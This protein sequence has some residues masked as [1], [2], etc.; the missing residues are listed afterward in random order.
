MIAKSARLASVLVFMSVALVACPDKHKGHSSSKNVRKVKGD[1]YIF[2]RGT[3]MNG[4]QPLSEDVVTD[5]SRWN[6][7]LSGFEEDYQETTSFEEAKRKQTPENMKHER[8]S[9]TFQ[10][11]EEG[12]VIRLSGQVLGSKFDFKFKKNSDKTII[13]DEMFSDGEK[14]TFDDSEETKLLHTSV[15]H[16]KTAMSFLFYDR[17]PG[18]RMTVAFNFVREPKTVLESLKRTVG[19]F[20]FWFGEDVK[21]GWPRAK[22]VTVEVC[23]N[24]Q[25]QTYAEFTEYAVRQWSL[26]L[27]DRLPLKSRRNSACPPFSDLNTH[28]TTYLR[29]WIEM[30]SADDA[31]LGMTLTLGDLNRGVIV[32]SDVF[33]LLEEIQQVFDDLKTGENISTESVARTSYVD[34]NYRR[35]AVHELG[36]LLGLHHQFDPLYPS[37]MSY[38][39]RVDTIRDYDRRAIRALY[40]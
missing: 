28:T 11:H 26:V 33:Y 22:P 8:R 24:G 31:T 14:Q 37:I 6:V 21:V 9:T 12:D 20:K 2:V 10:A 38:D 25:P 34:S 3:S 5:G 36:H 29:E 30:Q 1:P 18:K 32:D 19:R 7:Y 40:E 17:T 4:N 35:T 13:L 39:R 16:D 27:D 15:S 23:M